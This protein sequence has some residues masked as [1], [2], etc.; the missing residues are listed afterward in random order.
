[1]TFDRLPTKLKKF[2]TRNAYKNKPEQFRKHRL[3]GR[4]GV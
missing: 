2:F 3:K 4:V 1:M